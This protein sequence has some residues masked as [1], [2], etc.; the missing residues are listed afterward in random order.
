MEKKEL[1]QLPETMETLQN[2]IDALNQAMNTM[3]DFDQLQTLTDRRDLLDRQLETAESRWLEL[4]E[5]QEQA[6]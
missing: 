3:T 4:E 2:E 5:K 6:A 1:E